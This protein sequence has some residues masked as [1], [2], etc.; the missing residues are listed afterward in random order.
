MTKALYLIKADNGLTKIGKAACP[1]SRFGEIKNASPI[2]ILLIHTALVDNADALERELHDLF[3]HKR[4]H[5]EWFKLSDQDIAEIASRYPAV[6]IPKTRLHRQLFVMRPLDIKRLA[7]L[8]KRLNCI[9]DSET[10]RRA[11]EIALQST[12]KKAS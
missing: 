10:F 3:T 4:S 12:N 5:G 1:H 9:S 7:E 11:L 6:E 8:R 2:P